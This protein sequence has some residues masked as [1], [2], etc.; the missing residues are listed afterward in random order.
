MRLYVY[1][2]LAIFM[3]SAKIRLVPVIAERSI[4]VE[5]IKRNMEEIFL[6]LNKQYPAI[7]VTGPR[8]VG[9]TAMLQ[10]LIV[11]EGRSR[12]YVSLDDL[13]MCIRDRRKGLVI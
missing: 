5:Y 7:L 13:K 11:L 1:V 10:K 3:I 8:Q 2:L 12:N 6:E 4:E 9:K